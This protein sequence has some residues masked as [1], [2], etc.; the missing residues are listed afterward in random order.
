M[1]AACYGQND[2]FFVK[3]FAAQD[4]MRQVMKTLGIAVY[5]RLRKKNNI[6]NNEVMKA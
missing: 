1:T 6:G 5:E 3:M 4:M 2:D